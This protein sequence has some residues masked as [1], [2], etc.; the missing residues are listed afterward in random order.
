MFDEGVLEKAD[1]GYKVEKVEPNYGLLVAEVNRIF[2]QR[3]LDLENIEFNKQPS[4][5]VDTMQR[6][7]E[8]NFVRTEIN[9]VFCKVFRPIWVCD[10]NP[11]VD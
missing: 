6:V 11:T 1:H 3:R 9:K 8:L 10:F 2:D 5:Q 7:E 4:S